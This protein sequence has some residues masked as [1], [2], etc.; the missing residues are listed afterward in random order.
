M[1]PL[2]KILKYNHGLKPSKPF[3]IIS[4]LSVMILTFIVVF[5]C[6]GTTVVNDFSSGGL[7]DGVYAL[8][9]TI[10]V[11]N[12]IVA[13]HAAVVRNGNLLVITVIASIA[14]LLLYFILPDMIFLV[15]IWI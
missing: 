8:L 15:A 12:E 14:L 10:A 7:P 9:I 13:F 11:V 5:F 6:V 2:K 1:N 3:T 4:L